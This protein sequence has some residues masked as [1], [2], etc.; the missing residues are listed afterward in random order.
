MNDKLNPDLMSFVAEMI[1]GESGVYIP[2]DPIESRLEA[3][4]LMLALMKEGWHFGPVGIW[5]Y[6]S[7]ESEQERAQRYFEDDSFPRLLLKCVSAM[8]ELPLYV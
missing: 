5:H 3:H 8:K 7:D 6:A 4:A 2:C 1:Y